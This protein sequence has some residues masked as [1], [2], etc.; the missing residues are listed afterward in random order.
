MATGSGHDY[1]VFGDSVAVAA[2]L[3]A[4]PLAAG[5]N[6]YPSG[7]TRIL[8][9]PK[10]DCS[11]IGMLA[12]SEAIANLEE[13]RMHVTRDPDWNRTGF[14]KRDQTGIL[15][16]EQLMAFLNYQYIKGDSLTVELDND[17]N[18]EF[19]SIG[20]CIAKIAGAKVA[21]APFGPTPPKTH[22]VSVTAGV[23]CIADTWVEGAVT[24]ENFNLDRE[25]SYRVL[26]AKWRGDTLHH[27]RLI[28]LGGPDRDNRPG[29]PGSDSE[30]A[31]STVFWAPYGIEFT[32]LQGLNAE[33]LATAADSAQGGVML[34]QEM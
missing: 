34:I 25:K 12:I 24:F 33:F 23:T 18:A 19:N 26:A 6:T 5:D 32:G 10:E 30:I 11:I 21:G 16:W 2:G 7:A 28:A 1:I 4:K 31:G 14:N 3:G 15:D 20:I 27:F 29:G 9:F 22:W 13:Y 17:N 8:V